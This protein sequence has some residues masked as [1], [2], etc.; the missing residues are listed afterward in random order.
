MPGDSSATVPR[1]GSSAAAES[2]GFT[3]PLVYLSYQPS[4]N[5]RPSV[6]LN[7]FEHQQGGRRSLVNLDLLGAEGEDR[8]D[9]A[10]PPVARRR[11]GADIARHPGVVFELKRALWEP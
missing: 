4:R 3:L 6:P 8:E 11:A 5:A 1:G 10:V 9:V 7:R 2:P